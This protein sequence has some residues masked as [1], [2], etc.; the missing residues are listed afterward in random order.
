MGMGMGRYKAWDAFGV[1][2]TVCGIKSEKDGLC[3]FAGVQADSQ[4]NCIMDL[5]AVLMRLNA[6]KV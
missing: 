5:G 6:L 2:P 4:A 1:L 3:T